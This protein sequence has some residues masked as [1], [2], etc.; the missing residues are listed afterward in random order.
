MIRAATKTGTRAAAY[1]RMSKEEQ[2]NSPAQ[3]RAELVKLA[4]RE[5]FTICTEFIDEGI[6]G[7]ATH[8]R[9]GFQ[10]MHAAAL[11]GEFDVILAWDQDRFGR[12]DSIEAGHWI[13]PLR[14][15]GVSLVTVGQGAI[16]W[17]DF[18]GRLIYN[19]QQEGKHQFLRDLARNSLRGLISRTKQGKWNGFAPYGYVVGDDGRLEFGK[20]EHVETVR[21]IYRLRL[22]GI[23]Y[24]VIA[25]KLNAKGIPAP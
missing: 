14:A 25:N 4:Q 8:K 7:D 22:L 11:R 9:K 17:N 1:V 19:V 16:D 12:F 3:Q 2:E 18:T 6:S 23:G 24:R 5:G 13:Y 20:P 15:A 10:A 21:E